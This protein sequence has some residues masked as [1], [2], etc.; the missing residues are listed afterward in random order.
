METRQ[1]VHQ[2]EQTA[3]EWADVHLHP[4]RVESPIGEICLA[5]RGE[6]ICALG[7]AHQ[8]PDLCRHLYRHRDAFSAENAGSQ[9][10]SRAPGGV[11]QA[12][13]A[14]FDGELD[15]LMAIPV[16]LA[17]TPFQK[18]VWNELSRI[19]PGRTSTYGEIARRIGAAGSVRAIGGAVGA[20]PVSLI[21]PCHRVIGS[22]GS[23]TGYAGGKERKHWLLVHEGVLLG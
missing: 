3:Q 13:A 16:E 6:M 8:W 5:F 19:L 12:L 10:Q 21:V 23:L 15:A 11:V 17:G 14:Y 1:A 20:N 4:Q 18:R 9:A 22:D 7:F 2:G